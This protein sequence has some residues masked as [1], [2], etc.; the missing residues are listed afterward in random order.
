M[1]Q[2]PLQD[3][4]GAELECAGLGFRALGLEFRVQGLGLWGLEFRA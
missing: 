2:R 1:Q 3:R 4:A